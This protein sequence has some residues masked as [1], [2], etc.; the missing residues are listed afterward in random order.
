MG[1][2]AVIDFLLRIFMKCVMLPWNCK[3]TVTG[4]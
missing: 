2:K 1:M 3:P 4:C